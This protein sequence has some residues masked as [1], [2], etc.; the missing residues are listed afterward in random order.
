MPKKKSAESDSIGAGEFRASNEL[1]TAVIARVLGPPKS[2][3]YSNVN[4][5]AIL[6]GDIAIGTVD[7][8]ESVLSTARASVFGGTGVALGIGIVGGQYRWPD[9]VMPYVIDASLSNQGRVTDALAH[10]EA[11]TDFRFPLRTSSNSATYPNYVRFFDD[12]GC[13][14]YVGMRGGVQPI[15]LGS[16]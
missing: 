2:V 4:G 13:Y 14:S 8:L 1:G 10:W 3:T 7:G 6:E 11:H 12:G 5:V 16:P 9:C 15:S